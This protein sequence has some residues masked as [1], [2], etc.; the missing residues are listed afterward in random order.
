MEDQLSGTQYF[1][2][3]NL[4]YGVLWIAIKSLLQLLSDITNSHALRTNAPVICQRLIDLVLSG[5][6]G[7]ELFVYIDN[8]ITYATS[9]EELPRKYNLLINFEKLI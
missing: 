2:V 1:S 7:Q 6:Q 9:L 5:L 4:A 3:C 8:I